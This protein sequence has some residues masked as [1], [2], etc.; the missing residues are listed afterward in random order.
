MAATLYLDLPPAVLAGA[1]T[2][3]QLWLTTGCDRAGAQAAFCLD[4]LA[5]ND[6]L[7]PSLSTACEALAGT[8]ADAEQRTP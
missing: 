2:H 3:L 4:R 6:A 8:I 5:R 7:D 1:L